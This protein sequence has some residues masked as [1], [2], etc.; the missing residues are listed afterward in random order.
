MLEVDGGL[1][2]RLGVDLLVELS[3]LRL[4]IAA[5]F[6][7]KVRRSSPS[8]HSLR[9]CLREQGAGL[10]AADSHWDGVVAVWS[11]LLHPCRRPLPPKLKTRGDTVFPC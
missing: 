6:A 8:L 7:A 4:R 9:S 10:A 5:G 2:L 3:V 1:R 11:S